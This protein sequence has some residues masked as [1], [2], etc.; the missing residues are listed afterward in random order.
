MTEPSPA[1]VDRFIIEKLLAADPVLD[2][3]L[4]ENAAAE[5]PAI[6]VA[7]NQGKLLHLLARLS[8]AQRILEIG[9]LGGYSTIWLARALP[10]GGR[11]VTLELESRHAEV[12]RRNFARAGVREAIDLRV[13]P[14]LDTLPKLAD[15]G[16]APFDFVF[17][18]ADKPNNPAYVEWA[19]QLARPGATII[20]DNIVR[21]GRVVDANADDAAV[22]GTRRLFE[23]LSA[24]SRLD[25]TAVQTLGL[26]GHDGFLIGI[27]R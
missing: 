1:D 7:P 19:L 27:V 8:R 15:E 4:A 5:L 18:D 10:A 14:A 26:K 20:V 2:A 3:V 9:T 12:A 25:A 16:G 6:D 13:G 24:Q 23:Q 22:V 17:V 21:G 11:L